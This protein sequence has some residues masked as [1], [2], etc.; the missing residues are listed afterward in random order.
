MSRQRGDGTA[1]SLS[2]YAGIHH[3]D[4]HCRVKQGWRHA[5]PYRLPALQDHVRGEDGAEPRGRMRRA[6]EREREERGGRHC[7]HWPTVLH[8]WE[9]GSPWLV[10]KTTVLVG[11]LQADLGP[12]PSTPPPSENTVLV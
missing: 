9:I 8:L 10:L 5:G 12:R 6:E 11:I 3:Q 1:D 7:W 4:T 2:F